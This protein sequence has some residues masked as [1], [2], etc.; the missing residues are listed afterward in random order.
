[1]GLCNL[2]KSIGTV[3]TS[4]QQLV[5]NYMDPFQ[6]DENSKFSLAM[7]DHI[8]TCAERKIMKPFILQT[9]QEAGNVFLLQA[10][11]MDSEADE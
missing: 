3:A 1:M 8:E 11:D 2:L 10:K 9:D 4:L 5:F 6:E 7:V